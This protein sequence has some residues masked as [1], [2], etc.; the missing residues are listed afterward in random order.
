MIHL[1]KCIAIYYAN[2]F[3]EPGSTLLRCGCLHFKA[4]VNCIVYTKP[5]ALLFCWTAGCTA[6][7]LLTQWIYSRHTNH[8]WY[9]QSNMQ[10]SI[11]S[12]NRHS[13][14]LTKGHTEIV[15]FTFHVTINCS[16]TQ[17]QP[18]LLDSRGKISLLTSANSSLYCMYNCL[19]TKMMI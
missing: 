19:L 3:S 7:G 17:G 2:C 1:K 16:L 9:V 4:C 13:A 10:Y 14:F 18:W 12:L 6:W 5:T 15:L 11:E 8:L